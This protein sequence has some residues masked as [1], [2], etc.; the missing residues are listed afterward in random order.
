MKKCTPTV[1][2]QAAVSKPTLSC[3][4]AAGGESSDDYTHAVPIPQTCSTNPP[5]SPLSLNS[6]EKYNVILN[7]VD[8]CPR[9]T[10]RSVR[11]ESDLSSAVSVISSLVINFQSQ[12]QPFA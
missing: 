4:A 10:S 8:E 7:G 2:H 9:G 1:P 5:H 3:A 11:L 12:A 6:T